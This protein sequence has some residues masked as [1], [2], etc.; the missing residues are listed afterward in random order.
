[1]S[2]EA[3]GVGQRSDKHGINRISMHCHLVGC[4]TLKPNAIGNAVHYG[5][6]GSGGQLPFDH[7]QVATEALLNQ[8]EDI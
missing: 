3:Y 6:E 2:V 7:G 1:M 4:S 8:N 5:S